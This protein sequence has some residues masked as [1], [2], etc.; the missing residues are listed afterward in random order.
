LDRKCRGRMQNW[1]QT[2][3]IRATTRNYLRDG[4]RNDD[5]GSHECWGDVALLHR[6]CSRGLSLERH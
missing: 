2:L 5:F 1:G 6:T 3:E 4:D